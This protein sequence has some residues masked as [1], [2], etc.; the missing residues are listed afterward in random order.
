MASMSSHLGKPIDSRLI[1][2]YSLAAATGYCW[3][4]DSSMTDAC[5]TEEEVA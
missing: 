5:P 2:L 1:A 3:N 4:M